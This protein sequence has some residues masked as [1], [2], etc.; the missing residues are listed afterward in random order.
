M[1][2]WVMHF[3]IASRCR[4]SKFTTAHSEVTIE[5]HQSTNQ[6]FKV[7]PPAAVDTF[8][9]LKSFFSWP[10]MHHDFY[11]HDEP[12]VTFFIKSH[13]LIYGVNLHDFP[14]NQRRLQ[15][16]PSSVN[17]NRKV[18]LSQPKP[19][20]TNTHHTASSPHDKTSK[21]FLRKG[22]IQPSSRKFI[23]RITVEDC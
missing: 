3:W 16:Q 9:I 1:T 7:P 12:R 6:E 17:R 20:R 21:T 2:E 19:P 11:C 23:K 4:P 13:L 8:S 22:E 18:A 14:P 10:K 15:P 5:R